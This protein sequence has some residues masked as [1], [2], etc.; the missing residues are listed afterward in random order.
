VFGWVGQGMWAENVPKGQSGK[1]K[2]GP[3]LGWV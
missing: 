2:W 3:G 1:V